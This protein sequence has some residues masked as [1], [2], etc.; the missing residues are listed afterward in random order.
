MRVENINKDIMNVLYM[1]YDGMTDPLGQSQVIPYLTGLSK[2][3][4]SITLLSCEK[5]ENYEKTKD[6]ISKLLK[7]NGIIWEPLYYTSKPPV[8]STIYDIY[9][10]KKKAKSLLKIQHF[11]IV[12]C[13]SYIT[14]IIGLY[15]KK[16]FG[17]KFIF[18]MRG[19]FADER[20]EG[21]LWNLNNPLFKA[22]YK[23]FKFKEK[24]FFSEADYVVSLT[25]NGK[26][27]IHR[28][29]QIPNQPV[30]IEV[31]PCCADLNLFSENNFDKNKLTELK[32]VLSIKEDEFII[33]Y[34]GSIG[35]WY[36]LDEMLE[37][38][39]RLILK[40]NKAKFLFITPDKKE[41]IIKSAK[42]LG[43]NEDLLIIIKASRDEVPVYA[44]LSR[45]SLFFI[46]PVFSKKASSPTKQG[47]VMSLGIPIICN[48]NVG[49]TDTIINN[50]GTGFVIN[51]FS[52]AA[53]DNAVSSIEVL[54]EIPEQRIKEAAEK[55]YSLERGI[56]KYNKIYEQL[57]IVK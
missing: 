7:S 31:I 36:M 43:I 10:L 5:K 24:Q 42:K 51:E 21:G 37:F 47:E 45:V 49:D 33:S 54:L 4:H 13:R 50:T 18:D 52:D 17:V 26:N 28:W 9:R 44:K 11:D 40:Y 55:Y 30:P 3:G 16:K 38:F 1:S 35:T 46:K 53:Y 32:K 12:H 25:E 20:V 23:Y 15:L 48:A 22:V 57:K 8:L 19:F 56:E 34:L 39:K 27:E 6:K 29:K 14:S 41:F 2:R